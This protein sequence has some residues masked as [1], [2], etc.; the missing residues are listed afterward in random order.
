MPFLHTFQTFYNKNV[1]NSLWKQ[2]FIFST[3]KRINDFMPVE[4]SRKVNIYLYFL[5]TKPRQTVCKGF[6]QRWSQ[7]QSWSWSPGTKGMY[8]HTELWILMYVSSLTNVQVTNLLSSLL[9]NIH[10]RTRFCSL[11]L[12]FSLLLCFFFEHAMWFIVI[13]ST[14]FSLSLSSLC[15]PCF[16]SC[17]CPNNFSSYSSQAICWEQLGELHEVSE[18]MFKWS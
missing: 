3:L 8:V 1:W 16:F 14:S 6:R 10:Y 4:F 9:V 5:E 2:L 12:Y 13:M 17:V 11:F 7:C 15:S 18:N